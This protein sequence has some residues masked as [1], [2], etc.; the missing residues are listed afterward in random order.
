[1]PVAGVTLPGQLAER[2]AGLRRLLSEW[3]LAEVAPG[4][5][6]PWLAV[7]FGFGIVLYFTADREP[8]WWAA[9]GLAAV[10]SIIAVMARRRVFG[11]PLALGRS[12]RAIERAAVKP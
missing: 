5:L 10:T 11:F 8:A 12:F 3:A 9:L 7:A 1:M 4:R 2:S 6:V